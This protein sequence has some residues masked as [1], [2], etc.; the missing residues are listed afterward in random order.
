M[1]NS[2]EVYS[3]ATAEVPRLG[4]LSTE[5][6]YELGFGAQAV[7]PVE[8]WDSY[9]PYGDWCAVCKRPTDHWGE[10]D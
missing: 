9:D 2:T 8:Q 1:M 10:H 4:A 3:T 5:L 6:S 7:G